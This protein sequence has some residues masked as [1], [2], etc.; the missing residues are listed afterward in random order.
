MNTD[1]IAKA[2]RLQKRFEQEANSAQT[3]W[4]DEVQKRFYDDF[5]NKYSRIFDQLLN[6]SRDID[7]KSLPDLLKQVEETKLQIDN[8]KR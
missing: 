1:F 7:C 2:E 8:A 5:V 3:V 6:D 4:K